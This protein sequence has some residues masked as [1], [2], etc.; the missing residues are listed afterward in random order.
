VGIKQVDL[1]KTGVRKAT[2]TDVEDMHELIQRF[3][4]EGLML[5]RSTKSLYEHVQNFTVALVGG[6][7]V[8][9]AGLHILW[10]DLAEIRSLAVSSDCHGQGI[11]RLLVRE[12]QQEALELGIR[13][14]LS[15]T[16]QETFFTKLGFHVVHRDSLPHKV[17][18]DCV[19]CTKFDRC[20]EIA[21]IYE[22]R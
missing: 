2:V 19:F 15:L 8:G 14:V 4:D 20:D 18:K 22:T 3:A 13:Q 1:V 17:W 21:M 6:K 7:V 5:P 12:I 10:K 11:G 16:Y 9:T